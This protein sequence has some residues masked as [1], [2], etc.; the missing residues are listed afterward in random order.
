MLRPLLILSSLAP[1]LHAAEPTGKPEVV[2]NTPGLVAF[3]DFSEKEGEPRVSKGT[4]QKHALLESPHAVPRVE[5][6]PYSGFSTKLDGSHFLRVPRA[7][8]GNLDIHGKDAQVTLFT[9]IRVDDMKK[10]VTVAGI[11][12]EGKGAND[13]GGTRQYSLLLNMGMYGGPKRLVPHISSEGG[14]TR[15]ADGSAFPWC[16]D[17]AVNQS[18]I[19]VGK[20]VTLGS[21]YDGKYVRAYFNGVMEPRGLDPVKD[22][23]NDPYFIKEGPDGKDRGMNPYYHGRGIF[24]YDAEKHAA[25]KPDGAA[26]FTV[27]AC[28]AVGHKV[29]NPLIGL[30]GGIAVFNRALTDEEMKALHDSANIGALAE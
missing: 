18:E 19:P 26:D 21:T 11:W 22:R 30:V 12:S 7:Q 10:G 16:A 29:G 28:Y 4:E 25:T 23:R 14:V 3:W 6:G 17:Y 5:G 20:W 13:D 2:L 9:V 1:L 8:I 27:G 24:T 15:R